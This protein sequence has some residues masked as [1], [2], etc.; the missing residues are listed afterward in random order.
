MQQ[1]RFTEVLSILYIQS[2]VFI[3]Y[4]GSSIIGRLQVFGK[5]KRRF[6]SYSGDEIREERDIIEIFWEIWAFEVIFRG[7]AS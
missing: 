1:Y 3:V 2:S 6:A 5:F 7:I 4:S